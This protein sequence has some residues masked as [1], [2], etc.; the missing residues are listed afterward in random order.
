MRRVRHHEPPLPSRS[1]EDFPGLSAATLFWL[2]SALQTTL[3]EAQE[4]H[5]SWASHCVHL[6]AESARIRPR[7]ELIAELRNAGVHAL[8][9]DLERVQVPCGSFAAMIDL[10]G[11]T[12]VK[13][14]S[15]AIALGEGAAQP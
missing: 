8:A 10:D 1:H 13:V 2:E 3:A 7:R 4:H 9:R 12:C 15:L 14:C 11:R 5:V 6:E